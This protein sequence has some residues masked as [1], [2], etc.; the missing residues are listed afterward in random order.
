[1]RFVSAALLLLLR[2]FLPVAADAADAGLFLPSN[3]DAGVFL[4]AAAA[5]AAP[6]AAE[7]GGLFLLPAKNCWGGA[8]DADRPTSRMSSSSSEDDMRSITG[9]GGLLMIRLV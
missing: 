4:F 1:M 5:L 7:E 9:G 2:L 3:I 6:A 8:V